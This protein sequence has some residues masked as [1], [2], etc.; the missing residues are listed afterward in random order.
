MHSN[1]HRTRLGLQQLPSTQVNG[2]D[3][4]PKPVHVNR[5]LSPDLEHNQ[6]EFNK[7]F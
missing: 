5:R 1:N 3:P 7:L 6:S 4:D 2:I